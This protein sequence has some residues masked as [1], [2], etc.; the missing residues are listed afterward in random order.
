MTWIATIPIIVAVRPKV[1]AIDVSEDS[2][3]VY[4]IFDSARFKSLSDR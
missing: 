3:I 1:M 2:T 4:A